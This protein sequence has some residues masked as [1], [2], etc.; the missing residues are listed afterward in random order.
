MVSPL[1]TANFFK[2]RLTRGPTWISI[3]APVSRIITPSLGRASKI[4]SSKVNL[5]LV[6]GG[7]LV[8]L[9]SDKLT[10]NR[11]KGLLRST[12][13]VVRVAAIA[14][15]TVLG[16]MASRVPVAFARAAV[17]LLRTKIP[18]SGGVVTTESTG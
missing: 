4:R 15:K 2:R 7:R 13:R 3:L 10:I 5:I 18:R 8:L 9:G 16:Q 12:D 1:I 14:R 6:E 17:R 11:L